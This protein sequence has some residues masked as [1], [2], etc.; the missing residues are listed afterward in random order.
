MM[1]DLILLDINMPIMDGFEFLDFMED[2]VKN[3]TPIVF[4]VSSS[5]SKHDVDKSFVHKVVKE[6]MS[7]PIDPRV[8]KDKMDKHLG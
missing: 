1:P 5:N 2:T 3:N 7:K 8:L 4:M 6:Y